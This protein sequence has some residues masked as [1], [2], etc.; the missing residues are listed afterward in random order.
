MQTPTPLQIKTTIEVLKKYAERLNE[1]ATH[2]VIQMPESHL[3]ADYAARIQ[4][5]SIGQISH[6]EAVSA[7]LTN[8]LVEIIQPQ[9]Q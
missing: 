4:S 9:Q 5:Q 7:Q 2:S 1:Q 3:R 6:V 8:W